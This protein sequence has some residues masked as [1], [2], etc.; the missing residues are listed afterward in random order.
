MGYQELRVWQKG[1]DLA[2]LIFEI[3]SRFPN[4]EKYGIA[5]QMK[6]SA[7]SIPSNIAEG[8]G[9][10]SKK[11]FIQFLS[12]ARGSLNELETQCEIAKRAKL[13]DE[14]Q[15]TKV[16][17]IIKTIRYGMNAL[18]RRIREPKQTKKE[19]NKKPNNNIAQTELDK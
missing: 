15:L 17:E 16:H 8:K 1:V 14:D 12:V 9:R 13:I 2:T 18:M 19:F 4:S 7:V 5:D 3:T 10:N 11:E 6:R